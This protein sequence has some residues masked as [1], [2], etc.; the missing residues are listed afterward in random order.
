MGADKSSMINNLP[1][2]PWL[3]FNGTEGGITLPPVSDQVCT[4]TFMA[5]LLKIGETVQTWLGCQ[6]LWLEL[7]VTSL[8]PHYHLIIMSWY[9]QAPACIADVRG[10]ISSV[11]Y[12]LSKTL[13]PR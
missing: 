12:I 8:S 7:Q 13:H 1:C 4:S 9:P 6:R 5:R 11:H 2:V 10:R 3:L